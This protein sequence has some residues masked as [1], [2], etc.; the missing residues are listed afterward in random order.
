VLQ[1]IRE[2]GFARQ[3]EISVRHKS[4]TILEVLA[5]VQT[6]LLNGEKY[7]LN[8]LYDITERKKT[9]K[10]LEFANKELESFSYSVS[11]DLRAPLRSQIGY[12]KILEE[13]YMEKL[14]ENG[15]RVL[16]IVQRNALKMNELIENL[17]E[18]SKVGK[19]ELR[20]SEIDTEKL[21]QRV[22]EEV[23][24]ATQPKP[25]TVVHP[26]AGIYADQALINQV[27]INLLSNAF[28]YSSKKEKPIIEIGCQ[29]EGRE[30]VFYVKDNGSG[31]DMA[32][33]DRLF[34]VFQ[35]LHG[36]DFAGTGVGLSIV[37]RIINRHDGRVWADAKVGEGATFYFSLPNHSRL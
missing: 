4:G 30:I 20:K 31:F 15:K 12:C 10:Q 3:F 6:I 27:W 8:I 13:D 36:D 16:D 19:R 1:Q 29:T 5:S 14:D 37:K 23:L 21:V 33:A 11:H 2:H 22:I 18:F 26:L 17:L 32:Y 9:E 25:E 24:D 34:G 28:K 7:A 35:R